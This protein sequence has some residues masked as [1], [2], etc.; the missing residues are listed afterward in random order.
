[1]T[2]RERVIAA[3]EFTGPD[4]LPH[5]HACLPAVFDK[6]G[7]A[8]ERLLALYPSDFAGEDGTRPAADPCYQKGQWTDAWGCA[9][10]MLQDGFLGQVTGHPLADLRA[11]NRYHPPPAAAGSLAA[12]EGFGLKRADKYVVFTVGTLWE[13]MIDLI[14]F[15]EVMYQLGAGS[16]EL[17]RVRDMIVDYNLALVRRLLKLNP[18]GLYFADDW[19]SQRSLMI[20]PKAW[21]EI[22]RSSY[23]RMFAAV[24]EAGKHV[25]FHT[26][27]YTI[28]I[29]PDL[30]R[31]G[32]DVFWADLTLNGP[33]QLDELLGGQVCF[34]G[35]TDIQFI[36]PRGAPGEAARHT[37]ELAATF[38]KYQG[39][40]IACSE[41]EPDQPLANIAA[42]YAG[43]WQI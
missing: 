1:M 33:R 12:E 15:E 19:G 16:P 31:A 17:L 36:L 41:A 4:R 32:V 22:F 37:R 24:R 23:E 43:F 11:L 27:G 3:I 7:A 30:A 26:D 39:G 6:Y 14:G 35:L 40:F 25:F 18:D 10:T 2:S 13:R 8:F 34:Q 21:R 5:R 9:W 20:S 28:E 42:A 38:G 29:L